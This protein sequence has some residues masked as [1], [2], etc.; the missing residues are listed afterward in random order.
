LFTL[1]CDVAPQSVGV[2]YRQVDTTAPLGGI[3]LGAFVPADV[4]AT[5]AAAGLRAPR[6]RRGAVLEADVSGF[7]PLTERLA[8]DH[9]PRR[10]AE[11][12][13]ALLNSIYG[14]LVA[15]A[16]AAGG[17]VVEFVGDAL[18]CCFD[19]D[20]GTRALRCGVRMQDAIAVLRAPGADVPAV[21]VAVA[22]GVFH[23]FSVGDPAV[24]LLEVL[25]GPAVDAL[26][27]VAPFAAPGEVVVATATARRLGPRVAVADWRAS[28][29][30]HYAV[31][32]RVPDADDG[33]PADAP[34]I[35]SA[36]ARPWLPATVF[37]RLQA[38]GEALLG[39]L[40][41]VVALFARFEGVAYG[42][43]VAGKQLDAYVCFAQAAIEG[44]GGALLSLAVD[45]KGS[46]LCA[47]FGAPIAHDDDALRAAAA[48]L[49]LRSFRSTRPELVTVFTAAVGLAA[50]RMYA[51]T[52]GGPT[53]RTF[54][55][56]GEKVNLAARLM[57][58]ADGRRILV[59]EP[60]ARRL[61]QRFA[62]CAPAT[63]AVKGRASR[64]AVR[65]LAGPATMRPAAAPAPEL[66]DR[67]S[68]RTR[69]QELVDRLVDE[70]GTA[71]VLEGEPGIGKSRLAAHLAELARTAGARVLT[72]AGDPIERGAPYHGWRSIFGDGLGLDAHAGDPARQRAHALSRLGMLTGAPGAGGDDN[73]GR[74]DLTP[75]LSAV[76]ELEL[77][78]SPE[79]GAL[80]GAARGEATR[81]LLAGTLAALA[82]EHPTLV[83]LE[84]AHWLDSAS[85]ALALRLASAPGLLLLVMTTR[86]IA[87][88]APP[89]V[90]RIAALPNCVHVR[91]GPLPAA[92]AG[93][94]AARAVGGRMPA[95][96]VALIEGK[97]GGNP[98]FA[99]ELA[100]TLRDRGLLERGASIAPLESPASVEAVIAGRVD[101]IPGE[102]QAVLKVAS[103]LGQ[104]F[105][106]QALRAVAGR[107]VGAELELLERLDL[108]GAGADGL[109]FRHALIRDVVYERLLRTQRRELH[110][111]T[112]EFLETEGSRQATPAALAHHWDCA[113]MPARAAAYFGTAGEQALR[114]GAARECAD[115]LERA[116]Q[117][118][119]G[120]GPG[121]R[122]ARWTF[123]LSQAH[124][125][126]GSVSR[127]IAAGAAAIA[128]LDRP[129]PARTGGTVAAVLREAGCQVRRRMLGGRSPE[130][131]DTERLAVEAL[132]A[133][134]EI[135]YA[136]ADKPR[137]LYVALRSLNLA[138]RRG[139]SAELAACYGA[140]CIISGVIGIHALAR[141]YDAL[142][143]ATAAAVE[144]P[145]TT[146]LT[147]QQ[148]AW[149]RSSVGP[150]DAFCE[151]VAEAI[152]RFEALAHKPR[153]RDALGCAGIGDLLFGRHAQAERTLTTLL[154]GIEPQ[155]RAIWVQW[156]PL[157]LAAVALRC[158]EPEEAVARLRGIEQL[159]AETVDQTMATLLSLA[160]LAHWRAGRE[161]D[162]RRYEEAA[163]DAARRLGRMPTNHAELVGRAAL[164]ELAL[165]R[166]DAAASPAARRQ[167]RRRARRA[168]AWLRVF[169]RVFPVGVPTRLLY[170]AERQQRGGGARRARRG[171]RRSLAAAERLDARHEQALAHAALG[172]HLPASSAAGQRHRAHAAVGLRAVG[173]PPSLRAVSPR[174]ATAAQAYGATA[175]ELAALVERWRACDS[176]AGYFAAL[177]THVAVAVTAAAAHDELDDPL[178]A[179]RLHD[180]VVA[181][182]VAACDRAASAP[183]AWTVAFDAAGRRRGDVITHVLLAMNAHVQVDL[184]VAL[185]EAL[186][187][188]GPQAFQA[189]VERYNTLAADV[190]DAVLAGV[191]G[192]RRGAD[193]GMRAARTAAWERARWLAGLDTAVWPR[194]IA[195]L[196]AA[197]TRHAGAI[198]R[199]T[200]RHP[201]RPHAAQTIADLGVAGL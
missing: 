184:P 136:A 41:S 82:G 162:A 122:R 81:D 105:S 198:L 189:D 70:R 90:A 17:T 199:T 87:E 157:F 141:R 49:E 106:A 11:E 69:L 102:A 185:A 58:A 133:M 150:H 67:G 42:E 73:D 127:S 79:S 83:M 125:R 117:L 139:P 51:G 47:G 89:E 84:D 111:R 181:R 144:D 171:W 21:T 103:V 114:A 92:D 78:D 120:E 192:A 160:A 13:A 200:A 53:R 25:A 29:A 26:I 101:R 148:T 14:A 129:V 44:Y 166:W 182:Y 52:Y 159:G 177:L 3:D 6:E 108:L 142:A 168:C 60:L 115:A 194:A 196:D 173:A 110:R 172:D 135:Y 59:E 12:V 5:I 143:R 65:E 50:G 56:Q 8:R 179:L 146:A 161:G 134:G 85:L 16:D 195:E 18:L 174:A 118:T 57:Q 145:Y 188:D 88:S 20:D 163:W 1:R 27:A 123:N 34:T 19:N 97:S 175:A 186:G 104:S 169:A 116:L 193:V 15:E 43:P 164:A 55:L 187:G 30:V 76:A 183:E 63:L 138:E 22:T 156:A 38:G 46:Y 33:R 2:E 153:L 197:A 167:A 140:M 36:S 131:S 32:E 91:I 152:H 98:L 31:V 100:F 68:E 137:S 66:V 170:E 39:E 94:L 178:R 24:R 40:R 126:L 7:T 158:G 71:V 132:F 155:E 54:G 9:G 61:E 45:A 72:G 95:S 191:A 130:R 23:R 112:A 147:L 128:A 124:Y 99:R 107:A 93:E 75:L 119:A 190:V 74:A 86:P 37:D 151:L 10:G 154:A 109:A 149:Y 201:G 4:R 64:V 28:G 48:A 121:G 176:P 113:G 77:P 165:A 80:A 180:L 35:D 62:L 96:A